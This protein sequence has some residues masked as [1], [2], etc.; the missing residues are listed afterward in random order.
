MD[1]IAKMNP[2]SIGL[3]SS[4]MTRGSEEL[5]AFVLFAFCGQCTMPLN[6]TYEADPHRDSNNLGPTI[7]PWRPFSLLEA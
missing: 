3:T 5:G 7:L 4:K 2:Q 6:M 1:E